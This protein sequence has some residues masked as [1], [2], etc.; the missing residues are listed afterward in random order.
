[1]NNAPIISPDP[2]DVAHHLSQHDVEEVRARRAS[3]RRAGAGVRELLRG[4][5]P[6]APASG[7][8]VLAAV[9][10]LG[11][12]WA[13]HTAAT[14]AGDGMLAQILGDSPRLSPAVGRLRREHEAVTDAL[15]AVE[16]LLAQAGPEAPVGP[17]AGPALD[18]LL[19]AV[20]R[21][22]RDGRRLIYD[23]Y[24]VDLGLGE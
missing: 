22:R 2:G 13:R 15:R 14:E 23:A 5:G 10:E 1:M 20:D 11:Q 19:D 9:R 17:P 3:L 8:A 6:G 24:Q 4:P 16:R 18:R 21:H 7:G 12:V